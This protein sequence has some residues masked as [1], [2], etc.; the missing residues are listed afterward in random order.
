[1]DYFAL[2]GPGL[3]SPKLFVGFRAVHAPPPFPLVA[4]AMS[5]GIVYQAS[6]LAESL[7]PKAIEETLIN[8]ARGVTSLFSIT[9]VDAFFRLT[10][11]VEIIGQENLNAAV[12]SLAACVCTLIVWL[13]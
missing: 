9:T 4:H 11:N 12:D 5:V 3:G 6:D 8:F 13:W 1:M 2:V 10:E 7:N